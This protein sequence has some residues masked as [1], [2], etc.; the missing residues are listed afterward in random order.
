MLGRFRKLFSKVEDPVAAPAEA[1]AGPI[2][3]VEEILGPPVL[4]YV[5]YGEVLTFRT[6]RILPVLEPFET[7]LEMGEGL[8][9]TVTIHPRAR[10]VVGEDPVEMEYSADV[11]GP[12]EA[13]AWLRQRYG[14]EVLAR[15][16]QEERRATSRH[17]N[18]IRVRSRHLVRFQAVT[19]DLSPAGVRLIAEGDVSP[20][21]VLDMDIE[22]D[23]DRLPDVKARGQVVWSAPHEEGRTWFLGLRFTEVT[24]QATLDEYVSGLGGA[25][26]EGLTR[27]NFLD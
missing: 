26:E 10:K 11:S 20:G 27:K 16:G 19:H 22:L 4:V 3:S 17:L 23:H 9:R 2:P 6:S 18:R 25:A 13:L 8:S 1:P 14:S 15:G 5:S 24:E 7:T 12:Q 21:T